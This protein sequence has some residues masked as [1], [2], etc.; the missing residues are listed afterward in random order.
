MSS[1]FLQLEFKECFREHKSV[2]THPHFK[3]VTEF[4][5]KYT[6]MIVYHIFVLL[7]G[8]LIAFI[9]GLINAMMV[10]IHVWLHGPLLKLY[11]LWTYAFAAYVVA[12]IR[13]MYQ[14]LVDASARVFRQIRVDGKLNGSYAE[15]LAGSRPR[16][17]FNV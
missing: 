2:Q 10:F 7:F 9:G 5:Y 3:K 15:R 4:V 17:R 6:L 1:H 16:E 14:P 12:P 11:L 8:I 13:A